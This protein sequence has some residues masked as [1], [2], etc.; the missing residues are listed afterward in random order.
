M[1]T[2]YI[3]KLW[4]C[5]TERSQFT[6]KK[7]SLVVRKN[8]PTVLSPPV[9]IYVFVWIINTL[10]AH[11]KP[12]TPFGRRVSTKWSEVNCTDKILNFSLKW[13][14]CSTNEPKVIN[15]IILIE[16]VYTCIYRKQWSRFSSFI[17][18]KH[19]SF[20]IFY[21]LKAALNFAL[22]FWGLSH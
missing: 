2:V 16:V 18:M 10:E 5:W 19:L 13:F 14:T 3:C 1:Y 15:S 17:W 22:S 7:I 11:C 12:S 9:S 20:S 6:W 8:L 21:F 4:H